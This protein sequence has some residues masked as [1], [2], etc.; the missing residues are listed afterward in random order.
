MK[1]SER[2]CEFFF[3]SDRKLVKNTLNW[4]HVYE[5]LEQVVSIGLK[6]RI[7][8]RKKIIVY[9]VGRTHISVVY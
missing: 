1:V 8:A 2:F 7:S 3:P 6:G 4:L 9:I 5:L